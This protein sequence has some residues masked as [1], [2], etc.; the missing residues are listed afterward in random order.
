MIEWILYKVTVLARAQPAAAAYMQKY[1]SLAILACTI[2]TNEDT[3][4]SLIAMCLWLLACVVVDRFGLLNAV[5]AFELSH[6]H[7][8]IFLIASAVAKL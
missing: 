5:A 1:I 7:T 3:S 6:H 2:Q 4:T 8:C